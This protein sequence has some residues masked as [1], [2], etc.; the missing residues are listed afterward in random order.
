MLLRACSAG[1]SPSGPAEEKGE[2][3]QRQVMGI[4]GYGQDNAKVSGPP[5][6]LL[7]SSLPSSRP[8]I[9][10][11]FFFGTE[12][13]NCWAGPAYCLPRSLY[14]GGTPDTKNEE[15]PGHHNCWVAY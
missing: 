1:P 6:E 2:Q 10:P 11:N 5:G 7:F 14:C 15:R 8:S 12:H 3:H 4:L 13:K 9:S